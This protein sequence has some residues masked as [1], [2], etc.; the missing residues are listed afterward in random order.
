VKQKGVGYLE[1]EKDGKESI[2]EYNHADGTCLKL[3]IISLSD[4]VVPRIRC[5]VPRK[6]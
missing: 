2:R 1:R 4:L 5:P 6:E 3:F